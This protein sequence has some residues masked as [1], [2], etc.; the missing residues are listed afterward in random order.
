MGSEM[1][2]RDR[3]K[4]TFPFRF[5]IAGSGEESYVA[6]L[7]ALAMSYGINQY[8]EWV[9]WKSGEEKFEY[10]SG[11]DLFALTSHSENFAIVVIES[12]S[13]GTPVL[14][15]DQVGLHKYVSNQDLG[16]VTSLEVDNVSDALNTCVSQKE[17]A[18]R[19]QTHA[20]A[21]IHT[22]YR[23]DILASQYIDYYTY[24]VSQ[25]K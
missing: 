12:L 15:S 1:C 20:P 22:E 19:I 5:K 18:T 11:L 14:I 7:K 21:Q 9:G 4:V 3:S 8:I 13:V 10:L 24:I 23:D 2:I 17:K 6:S 16:W 25:K